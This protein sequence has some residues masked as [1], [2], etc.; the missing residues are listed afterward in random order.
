MVF[1]PNTHDKPYAWLVSSLVLTL[2]ALGLTLIP[3]TLLATV[4]GLALLTLLPGMQLTRWL[5]LWYGWRDV[6]SVVLS[7][8]LGLVVMPLL[9]FWWGW[10]FDLSRFGIIE[11]SVL[12]VLLLAWLNSYFKPELQET[13]KQEPLKVNWAVLA[14]LFLLAAG[15]IL[16]YTEGETE[17]GSYPIQMGDWVK[18]HGVTWSLRYTGIIEERIDFA[19]F[20][21]GCPDK[22]FS[23]RGF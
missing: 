23:V 6:K 1:D 19:K 7:I 10:L 12:F 4:G 9:L 3:W 15:I 8:A 22:V 17:L 20:V 5:S 14:I 18:H 11:V 2:I 13:Q 21:L 16:V